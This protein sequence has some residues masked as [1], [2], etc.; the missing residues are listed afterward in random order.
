MQV[1]KAYMGECIN[2]VTQ[3]LPTEDGSLPQGLTLQNVYT[4]LRKDSKNA[5]MEHEE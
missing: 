3:V 2:I 1:E 4:K 5:V